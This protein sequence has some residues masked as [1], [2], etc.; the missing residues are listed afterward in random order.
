MRLLGDEPM[1]LG[2][3]EVRLRRLRALQESHVRP[4]TTLVRHIRRRRQ[5]GTAVPFFD[6]ADGGT[7]AKV[8]LLLEAPGPKAVASGFVSRNNPDPTAKRFFELNARARLPRHLTVTWNIV[9]WYL[10]SAGKIRPARAA[11]IDEAQPYLA[12]LLDFLP[13]LEVVL[14]VGRK[15][16]R[17]HTLISRLLPSVR[18]LRMPH[19]GPRVY[20]TSPASG[21]AML[22]ALQKAASLVQK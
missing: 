22:R 18:I 15:A 14:L 8:L 17:S 19:P 2:I 1:S 11:D 6:P 5:V 3:P 16:Q 10:G 13:R 20:N 9:P 12:K 4:L 7:R 21:R